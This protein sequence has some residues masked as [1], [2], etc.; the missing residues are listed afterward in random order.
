ME[1]I[2]FDWWWR[3]HQSLA[4]KGSRIF[5]FCDMPWKDEREPTIKCCLGRQV[6]MAQKFITIQ[7]FGH[8]W[9]WAN[10]IRVEYFPRI[11]TTLQ[12]CNKSPR[13]PV[14]KMSEEPEEFTGRIIFMSMFN[15]ISLGIE[16]QGTG[17]RCWRKPRFFLC[18][19]IF[20][21]K[22][23]IPRTWITKEVA[24]YLW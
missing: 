9:W 15:D 3:S 20:T 19:K 22:M 7:C 13:V 17:R 4:R 2:I 1:T 8:N 24:F 21:W 10:G 11:L 18:K 23:V 5:R 14:E 12:L 16:R 6:D